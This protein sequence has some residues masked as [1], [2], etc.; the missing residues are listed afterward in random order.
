MIK[1]QVSRKDFEH[2]NKSPKKDKA[3]TFANFLVRVN[4]S[5]RAYYEI[6]IVLFLKGA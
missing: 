6:T 3:M 2:S 1:S 4:T 5:V